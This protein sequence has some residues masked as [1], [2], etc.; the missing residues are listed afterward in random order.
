MSDKPTPD[1]KRPRGYTARAE[2]ELRASSTK[3]PANHPALPVA[4]RAA[5]RD[6]WAARCRRNLIYRTTRSNANSSLLQAHV[7]SDQVV[8]KERPIAYHVCVNS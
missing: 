1:P 8:T 6:R 7:H 3:L 5:K 2:N 4:G